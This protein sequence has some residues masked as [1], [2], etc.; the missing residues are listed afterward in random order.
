MGYHY[1]EL[2]PGCT[3]CAACLLVCPDFVFEV[4]RFDDAA[5]ARRC[6]HDRDRDRAP[7][8]RA[9][10]RVARRWREAAIAAGCR[11]FAG[12]PMTPFTELLEHFAKLP[13]RGGRRVHQR[14][15]ASS[16]R[17]GWRGARSRPAPAP[18]PARPARAS[19]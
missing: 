16:K 10:G 19:R 12:Y 17:S 1:P 11:F 8:T 15:D 14:R 5:R 9:H 4:F 2:H 18:R 13:A 6:R 7:D 3:G